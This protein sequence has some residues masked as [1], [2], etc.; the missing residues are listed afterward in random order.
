[1]PN[2]TSLSS[3]AI[4]HRASGSTGKPVSPAEQQSALGDK[5]DGADM[6]APMGGTCVEPMAEDTSDDLLPPLV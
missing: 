4:V 3:S 2:P 6:R 5:R 1:M